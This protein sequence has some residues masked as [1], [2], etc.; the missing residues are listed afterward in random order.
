MYRFL[1]GLAIGLATAFAAVMYWRS[2]GGAAEEE[3]EELIE[4]DQIP[5]PVE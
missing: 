5:L 2:R 3:E 1:L 4:I